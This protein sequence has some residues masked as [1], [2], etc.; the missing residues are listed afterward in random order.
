VPKRI[1]FQQKLMG[2]FLVVALL[3]S[4]VLSWATRDV[5]RDRNI[6]RNRDVALEKARSAEAALADLVRREID[7]VRES[8]YLREV[9]NEEDT[10]PVRDIGHLEFSQIMVFKGD[11]RLVLD[12][13]LSNLSDEEARD[14]V[15]GAPGRVF[16]SRDGSGNL[17]LGALVPVWYAP[18]VGLSEAAEEASLYYLYYRRRLTDGVLRDLAPIL[19]TD[20]SG[21]LGPELVVSSQ[22]GLATAGL[23]PSLVPPDA[24][25]QIELR[26]NRYA[27]LEERVGDQVFFTGYLPLRDRFDRRI[28]SLAVSQ[29]LQPDAFAAESERTRAVVVGLSTV[30]F[31]LTLILGVVFA[32]RIFDPVRNLIEGTQRLAGGEFG[33]RLRARAGDE[34]GQLERSFND[35]AQSLQSASLTLEERRRYLEAVL[36]NVASGVV[37]TDSSGCIT[38][39]NQAVERILHRRGSSLEGRTCQELAAAAPDSGARTLWTRIGSGRDG[40]EFEVTLLRDGERLALRVIATDLH[41]AESTA[42]SL[43]RVAIFEDVTELIRSKKLSAWAEMARQVAH[44]IKNPLTPLK[45]EA[46]FMERAWRDRSDKFPQI[47]EDGMKTIIQ[48]VDALRAIAIEFSN[49]GRV[50]KLEPRPMDLGDL[51]EGVVGPYSNMKGLRVEVHRTNGAFPG[52]GTQVLADEEGLRKVFRNIMENARESMQGEGRI[53]LRVESQDDGTVQVVITDEGHGISNDAQER[54]FEPYFSTKST[55]TGLG[56]AITRGILEELGGRI[57]LANRPQGG[58]EARVTLVVC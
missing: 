4:L 40:E 51:L 16:A 26:R 9:L 25:Q 42:P 50:Q 56:L 13:T 47:F 39:T 1:G 33:F 20:I 45:S 30:M 31:V 24:F 46:Q 12:E 18:D 43:G 14:F 55:G 36:G 53:D 38:A 17:N 32:S 6:E 23:L 15:T 8:E 58:A 57:T 52:S 49:Y 10:P 28:G 37:A 11:G 7:T 41:P 19:N 5:T 54:L 34:I 21:F 48:Q 3:P 27:V 22:M 2:A 44:E 29:F 35:M